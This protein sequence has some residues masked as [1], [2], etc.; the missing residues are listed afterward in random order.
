MAYSPDSNQIAVGLYYGAPVISIF[1]IPSSKVST[2]L[3]EGAGTVERL[4]YTA[5][6]D[7]LIATTT[8]KTVLLWDVANA[9]LVQTLEGHTGQINSLVLSSDGR[10]IATASSDGTIRIWGIP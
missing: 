1:D 6:G 5:A 4:I 7:L 3:D 8:N 10:F 9:Q 2:R